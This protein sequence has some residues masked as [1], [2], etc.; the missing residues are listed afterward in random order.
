MI[1]DK[2]KRFLVFAYDGYYPGGGWGDFQEAF[3]TLKEAMTFCK[4]TAVSSYDGYEIV[5]LHAL[6]VIDE[7]IKTDD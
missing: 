6:Q 3:D 2:I 1:D 7:S 5:D 4:S